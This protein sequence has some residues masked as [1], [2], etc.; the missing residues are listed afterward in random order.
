[1]INFTQ[2]QFQDFVETAFLGVEPWIEKF[3]VTPEFVRI[4]D[5]EGKK[6]FISKKDLEVAATK[7]YNKQNN[8]RRSKFSEEFVED[9]LCDW[10]VVDAGNIFQIAMFNEIVYC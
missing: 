5:E 8:K 7:Y 4:I 10:D 9:L 6:H 3:N 1:M 2:E